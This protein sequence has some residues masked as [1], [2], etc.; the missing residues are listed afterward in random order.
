LEAPVVEG[1]EEGGKP[2]AGRPKQGTPQ[3]GVIS[4]RLAN[5]DLHWFDKVFYGP[6]GPARWAKAK[7]VRYADDLVVLAR[8]VGPRLSG[9]MEAKLESWMGLEINREKTRVLN[10][11][12]EGASLD[13]LGYTLRYDRDRFGREQRYWNLVPSKKALA[14]EREQRRARTEV[15]PSHK[16]LPRLITERNR[17]RKGWGNYFL[18]GYSRAAFRKVNGFVRD[19]LFYHLRRRSQ[20]PFRPPRGVSF[21]VH[22]ARLGLKLLPLG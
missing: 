7:L 13:F 12:Q 2:P 20:R 3:G 4:P 21:R 8:A 17:H 22:L 1:S 19:R 14:R 9:S 15:S 16:P 6:Q 11:K 5:L 10:L 18:L